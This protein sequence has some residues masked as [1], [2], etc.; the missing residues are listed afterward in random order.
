[1]KAKMVRVFKRKK[2]KE[3]EKRTRDTQTNCESKIEKVKRIKKLLQT[4][5]VWWL[6]NL[7]HS[8]LDGVNQ[9]IPNTLDSLS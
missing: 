8:G 1:M 5:P 7:A 9:E 3:R 4:K 2:D 6:E